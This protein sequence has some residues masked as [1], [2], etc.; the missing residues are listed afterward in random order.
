MNHSIL[1]ACALKK[2]IS[3]LRRILGPDYRYAVTGLGNERT[4]YALE[5]L[6]NDNP[7][8]LLLFTGMAG[9]LSPNIQLGDFVF[10]EGWRLQS[11]T[12]FQSPPELVQELQQKRWRVEDFGLTVPTPVVKEKDRLALWKET[13]AIICDME[14]ASAMMVA[15]AYGV[16]CL[17]PKLVA[18]TAESGMLAFYRRF[19]QNLRSLGEALKKLIGDL[20]EIKFADS[21]AKSPQR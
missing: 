2:E 9:Q 15:S 4:A 3:G 12:R 10:P 1:I 21:R 6:F 16:P 19:D 13:G 5:S 14:S 7:P 11:G 17:A 8:S 18:D 20:E